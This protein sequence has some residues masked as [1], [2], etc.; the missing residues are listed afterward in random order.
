MDLELVLQSSISQEKEE[1]NVLKNG[2]TYTRRWP[3]SPLRN[4]SI[5]H[6]RKLTTLFFGYVTSII[7]EPHHVLWRE[8]MTSMEIQL[9]KAELCQR[10]IDAVR[11]FEGESRKEIQDFYRISTTWSSNA[12]EGNTLTM[13]ETKVL[14][15]DGITIGGKPLKDT[16]EACGHAEAYDYMFSLMRNAQVALDDILELHRL[17]YHK[18]SEKDAGIYRNTQVRITGS[19]TILPTPKEIPSRMKQLELWMRENEKT[20]KP[21]VYAAEL[22]R[23][24]VE[25]HPFKDGNGRTARLLMNTA[26]IQNGY[27]PCVI[28]P[29]IRLDYLQSLEASHDTPARGGDP[30]RFIAFVAEAE[31]ETEKDFIRSMHLEMPDFKHELEN[32]ER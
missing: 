15:E 17:F 18:I 13:G 29:A 24:F 7:I 5:F 4:N 27:L 19:E 9:V 26:L 6:I 21:L 28:S 2:A 16:L 20:L 31:T 25:I 8:N 23:R 3:A 32:M 11:P 1:N 14:L 30:D 22:Y 10:V 12:I